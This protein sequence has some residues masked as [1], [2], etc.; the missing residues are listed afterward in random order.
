MNSCLLSCEIFNNIFGFLFIIIDKLYDF[1]SILLIIIIIIHGLNYFFFCR[2]EMIKVLNNFFFFS[3]FIL[4][5]N[6]K[7]NYLYSINRINKLL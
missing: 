6:L 2:Q 4:F 3:K 1:C 7:F 5:N